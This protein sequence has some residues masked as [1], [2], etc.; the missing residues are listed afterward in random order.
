MHVRSRFI[1]PTDIYQKK[2]GQPENSKYLIVQKI[3]VCKRHVF[4]KNL[5]PP[6]SKDIS[7][8]KKSMLTQFIATGLQRQEP[9]QLLDP[10]AP[11]R[12]GWDGLSDLFEGETCFNHFE[13][14]EKTEQIP[15]MRNVGKIPQRFF[16]QILQRNPRCLLFLPWYWFDALVSIFIIIYELCG[17]R[18]YL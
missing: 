3:S 6:N 8:Q 16:R 15:W 10:D 14:H 9:L 4:Q 17:W 13:D 18:A 11:L 5:C 7:F 2:S 1:G 12:I